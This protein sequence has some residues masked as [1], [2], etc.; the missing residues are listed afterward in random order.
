MTT[1]RGRRGRI[2]ALFRSPWLVPGGWVVGVVVAAALVFLPSARGALGIL[3]GAVSVTFGVVL[4]ASV[5]V[6]VAALVAPVARRLA[7][8]ARVVVALPPAESQ[9]RRS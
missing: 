4:I 9:E 7:A 8:W 1:C 5:L 3:L 6:V 2:T